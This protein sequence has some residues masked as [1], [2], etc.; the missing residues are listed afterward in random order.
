MPHTKSFAEVC[1]FSSDLDSRE[2]VEA[3]EGEEYC[4]LEGTVVLRGGVTV[5]EVA[6]GGISL[7]ST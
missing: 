1:V 3:V 4:E 6:V 5:E 2:V 7:D